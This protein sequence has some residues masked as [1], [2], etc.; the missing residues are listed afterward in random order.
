MSIIDSIVISHTGL[1]LGRLAEIDSD[2]NVAFV[3]LSRRDSERE[4][5]DLVD[6]VWN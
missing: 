2:D 4:F 5:N 1:P 6:W 3:E